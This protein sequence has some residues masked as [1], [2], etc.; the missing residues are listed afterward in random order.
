M[1]REGLRPSCTKSCGRRA[2]SYL[3]VMRNQVGGTSSVRYEVVRTESLSSFVWYEESSKLEFVRPDKA[4]RWRACPRP[5]G[6][7]NQA[8]GTSSVRYEESSRIDCPHPSFTRSQAGRPSSVRY[9]AARKECLSLSIRYR[10]SRRQHFIHPVRSCAK[11]G[12]VLV[13]PV[14]GIKQAGLR[15]SGTMSRKRRAFPPPS[16]M[17]NQ[18]RR[19]SS[20]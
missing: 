17:W 12:L 14:S 2:C 11:G 16:S 7:S 15:P 13:H 1:K 3:S 20:V 4:T 18:A 6:T 8:G 9:E 5:S 19:N 10:Q